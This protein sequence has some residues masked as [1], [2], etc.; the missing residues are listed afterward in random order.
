MARQSK[1][2]P[3]QAKPS[4][5]VSAV[6]LAAINKHTGRWKPQAYT[7]RQANKQT[8]E[9]PPV[10]GVPAI[11]AT[12][13]LKWLFAKTGFIDNR[14]AVL[15]LLLFAIPVLL[16]AYASRRTVLVFGVRGSC[17]GV[18][19]RLVSGRRQGARFSLSAGTS[20]F[21]SSTERERERSVEARVERRRQRKKTTFEV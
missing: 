12:H 16:P 9:N 8:K 19:L 21:Q 13:R 1:N 10:P 15:L 3:S 20:A 14:L 4:Q 11:T 7:T 6:K 17:P 2:R 18:F 5:S